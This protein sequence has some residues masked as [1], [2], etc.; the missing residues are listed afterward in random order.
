MMSR[1]I[2]K[3]DLDW[4]GIAETLRLEEVLDELGLQ[5]VATRKGGE[6]LDFRC[7]LD[8]HP[9][10]DEKPS[11]GIN[12]EEL[13]WHCF[14]CDEGGALPSLVAYLEGFEENSWHRA[15]QWLLRFSN[16][17]ADYDYAFAQKIEEAF[18]GDVSP[19]KRIKRPTLPAYAPSMFSE[20]ELAP[21]ALLEKWGIKNK[22]T[23]EKFGIRYAPEWSHSGYKYTGSG[24][25]VPAIFGGKLVGYNIRWLGDL[26]PK[27]PKY[28]LSSGFP[29]KEILFN[30]DHA[31][32]NDMVVVEAPFTVIRLDELGIPATATFGASFSE[33]QIQL[34]ENLNSVKLSYDN[35]PPFKNPK[36]HWVIGAGYK[37]TAKMAKKLSE[38][39][40]VEIVPPNEIKKGDLADLS[41]DEIFA[42]LALSKPYVPLLA[43]TK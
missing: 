24:L 28:T 3:A 29:K 38:V 14:T 21:I 36:G 22:A 26:P 39:I 25:I 17:N 40:H 9:S 13:V 11:F 43:N 41:D 20:L 34:L 1:I 35:D 5:I 32:L 42:Q 23:I 27:M 30:W 6:Q 2:S 31:V 4:D 33:R 7:P 15:L 16:Y 12:S 10:S 37:A 8:T 18:G 19:P